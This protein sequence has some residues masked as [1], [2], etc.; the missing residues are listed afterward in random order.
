[1]ELGSPGPPRRVRPTSAVPGHLGSPGPPRQF[2]STSAAPPA[3]LDRECRARRGLARSTHHPSTPA[4][5]S[6]PTSAV[7]ADLGS[8]GRPRQLLL[9]ISTGSAELVGDWRGRPTTPRPPPPARSRPRQSLPTS[10]VPADLGNSSCRS[11][12]GVP[13]SSGTG[14]VGGLGPPRQSP[15][16]SAGPVHLG[17]CFCRSR[18]GVPSSPGTGGEVGGF[19]GSA[20]LAFPG[21]GTTTGRPPGGD[22]PVGPC[23]ATVVALVLGERRRPRARRTSS[24]S[25]SANVVALVL[26]DRGRRRARRTSSPS[27]SANVVAVGL[28]GP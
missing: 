20:G 25:C 2:R 26:G 28:S 5:R 18:P 14:E 16:T 11:R 21:R 13:S 9:P 23:S 4:S 15:S 7:P 17:S 3:D 19:E 8:P 27:C 10:A 1:M 12:P 22:R 6:Q 24:P